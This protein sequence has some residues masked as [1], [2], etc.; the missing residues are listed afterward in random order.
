MPYFGY[1][2]YPMKV[3]TRSIICFGLLGLLLAVRQGPQALQHVRAPSPA[4][5][6]APL[7]EAPL[8]APGSKF[9]TLPRIRGTSV[10]G[11]SLQRGRVMSISP[12]QRMPY[13]SR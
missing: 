9:S 10:V 6:C 2:R 11:R 8:A 5:S 4:A 1:S 7:L 12:T 3:R 13:V